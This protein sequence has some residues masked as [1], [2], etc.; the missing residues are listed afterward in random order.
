MIRLRSLLLKDIPGM[1]EWM[2]DENV[3]RF[4]RFD[5]RGYGE[6]EA[7]SFIENAGSDRQNLHFAIVNE[8]DEYQGTISLKNMDLENRNAEY[9]ICLRS[10]A[11]G[12]GTAKE[13]TDLL[14]SRAFDELGLHKVYLNVLAAN[15]RA[16]HFYEKYGFRYEGVLK[17]Q[18]FHRGVY[19]DLLYYAVF[20]S[21]GL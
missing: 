21:G 2:H 1:L 20:C 5:S 19:Q 18:V 3:I 12:R 10:S 6:A 8:A 14:L 16:I 7:R 4:F 9:A 17:E 13:A 15:K 11:M